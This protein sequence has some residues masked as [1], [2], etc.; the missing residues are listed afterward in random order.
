MHPAT[1]TEI[2]RR[3]L[4]S[5][6]DRAKTQ[7]DRNRLG[8]FATPPQLALDIV[9]LART[10]L[11]ENCAIRFLDPAFGTGAFYSALLQRCPQERI[12]TATGYEIDPDYA[13]GAINL[14]HDRPLKVEIADFTQSSPQASANLL[15]CNPPYTR[16]HHLGREQKQHLQQTTARNASIKLSGLAGLHCHF[17]CLGDAW[18]EEGGVAVWL[19]PSGFMDVNYGQPIKDY[20]L[21]RATLLRLHR[22][23]PTEVQFEDALVSSTIL[24]FK[25]A[26]PLASHAVCCSEGGS[27]TAPQ[28]SRQISLE[29]L[30]NTPKWTQLWLSPKR[31]PQH[32][33][34]KVTIDNRFIAQTPTQPS[35]RALK[36]SDLFAIKRGLATGANHF[37]ILTPE[38]IA[39]YRLPTAFLQPILPS[40]RYLRVD[41]IAAD[42][43]G[44]PQIE[45]QLYLLNCTLPEENLLEQYPQ[46]WRYLQQGKVQ[47]IHTRYLCRHR[48]PWY[49]QE[50]RAPAPFLC[51]YMGRTSH[52]RESPFRFIFNHSQATASNVYLMLY[53]KPHL[54]SAIQEHPEVL[55]TIWQKLARISA[56][57]LMTE[58]RVYGGGLHKLEPRELCNASLPALEEG[59]L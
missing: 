26:T 25:K 56:Q 28:R 30:S 18:M 40:P 33:G 10:W 3:G 44:N 52:H 39:Q 36:L 16:H 14:W 46:L 19:M 54:A 57:D 24:C 29:E 34:N 32:K 47:G 58:G 42:A 49:A 50:K 17:L 35:D 22:F 31:S 55:N 8:Q 1:T 11:P 23:D 2:A 51:T 12:L 7:S 6:L 4:N 45:R 21:T 15:L 27:L 20:L 13:K 9:D 41:E 5:R 59:V 48:S 43:Q 37:F 53:P 38:Q